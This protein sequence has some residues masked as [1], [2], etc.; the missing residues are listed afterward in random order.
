MK[1][2]KNQRIPDA[3]LVSDI[4]L[5]DD[6]PICRTDD[7]F[8]TQWK[9][10][11]FLRFLQQ[12]YECIILCAGDL[13]H[14]WKPSPFLLSNALMHMP[15]SFYT[16]WGQ[17]DLPQHSLQLKQKSGLFTLYNSRTVN[18]LKFGFGEEP[19]KDECTLN[20]KDR[21]ILVWHRFVWDGKTQPWPGC[22]EPTAKQVLSWF[23]DIDLILMGD[24][25]KT[26]IEKSKDGRLL[27]NPGSF[28]RQTA[29]QASHVPCVFAW[30]A[31]DNTVESIPIPITQDVISRAHIDVQT[32]R[33]E[34][35]ESFIKSLSEEWEVDISFE[36]NLE[37]FFKKNMVAESTRKIIY[38]ALDEGSQL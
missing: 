17:H 30:Y 7:F 15:S 2:T 22:E 19:K 11:D 5:R 33:N 37:I 26:F 24:N 13:F 4:H 16:V 1:R 38:K 25:H 36:Q 10:L 32:E 23:P 20:I 29:D 12:K 27:V 18:L 3:L 31:E 9:K 8:N 28:T 35:I 34:R 6:H 14:H 21:S